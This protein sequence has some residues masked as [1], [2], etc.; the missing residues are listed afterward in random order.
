MGATLLLADDSVTIQRVIEL[1]FAGEDVRVVV[2][3]DG[4][5][6]I[7]KIDAEHPDIVLADVGMPRLDGY[8]VAEH[9]KQSAALKHIPVLLLTGA[10]EPI[11]EARA[12]RTGCDGVL[13]KPFEPQKL[14]ARVRE[15]LGGARGPEMWPADMPRTAVLDEQREVA[16]PPLSMSRAPE[17]PAA[18]DPELDID[19]VL[20][21]VFDLTE[22]AVPPAELADALEGE[23]VAHRN[24]GHIPRHPRPELPP[25]ADRLDS[26]LDMLD[27]ALS[28]LDPTANPQELDEET[29]S[30][31]AR[32]LNDLRNET[33]HDM[34]GESTPSPRPARPSFG[35]WDLPKPPNGRAAGEEPIDVLAEE[36]PLVQAPP[37]PPSAPPLPAAP[38]V[39]QVSSPVAQDSSPVA[40]APAPVVQHAPPASSVVHVTPPLS[41]VEVRP[42][43]VPPAPA[44]P[45]APPAVQVP[46]A[47]APAFPEARATATAPAREPAGKP[48]HAAP[49]VPSRPAPP[50]HPAE[51]PTLAA[52]FSALL[53]A[54]KSRPVAQAAPPQISEAAI[55]EVVKRVLARMAGDTVTRVVLETAERM[56]R[57]EISRTKDPSG[58]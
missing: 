50:A 3:G 10:F 52:A 18:L 38:P 15:L 7:Q 4:Q 26:E 2:A 42:S 29:A 8:A 41:V 24:G 40:Q 48:A 35:S 57:E 17:A 5:Q 53:A 49:S 33:R 12:R 27:A 56:I 51:R 16:A 45:A 11:D 20:E 30:E 54:E 55:E 44:V 58:R 47:A 25:P 1:T 31:F 14:V 22:A 6:A 32:D 23:D 13:V 19:P 43:G 9:V 34:R 46:A 39:V 21:P 37:Q 28:R 36:I